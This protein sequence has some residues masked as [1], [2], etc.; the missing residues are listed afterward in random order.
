MKSRLLVTAAIGCSFIF[1]DTV[2]CA[3]IKFATQADRSALRQKCIAKVRTL[4]RGYSEDGI[5]P[6]TRRINLMLIDQCI[7]QGGRL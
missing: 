2:A 5:D 1:T 4:A 6:R 7:Q 3:A